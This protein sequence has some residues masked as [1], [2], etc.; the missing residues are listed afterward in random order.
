MD[1][2]TIIFISIIVLIIDFWIYKKKHTKLKTK[3]KLMMLFFPII[4]ILIFLFISETRVAGEIEQTTY[5]WPHF[6]L[7]FA[8][9]DVLT[10]E[11][12]N[13][14]FLPY[15]GLLYVVVNY[16]FYLSFVFLGIN[17]IKMSKKQ[18]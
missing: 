2:P 4:L 7:G 8:K 9:K 16:I 10:K 1:V 15:N 11:E 17:L 13:N 6:F 3:E 14:W 5:G 12:L 18:K